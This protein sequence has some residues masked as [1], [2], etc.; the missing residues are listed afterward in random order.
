M[1]RIVVFR[2]SEYG[3]IF[4]LG[5]PVALDGKAMGDIKTGSFTYADRPA[6]RHQLSVDMA[7]A[8]PGTPVVKHEF[9]AAPGR[10]Y[11]FQARLNERGQGLTAA[12]SV[13]GLVG[14][15]VV[16]AATSG[17]AKGPVDFVPIDNASPQLAEL[18]MSGPAN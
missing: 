6:G 5:W 10:T 13:G 4:D 15:A 8:Y 7:S 3:G 14:Y 1:A 9:T 2:A 18:R 17:D 16:T 12:A 11:Y